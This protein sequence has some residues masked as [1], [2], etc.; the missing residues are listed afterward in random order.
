MARRRKK[1]KIIKKAVKIPTLFQCP[2]CGSNTLS[3]VFAKGESGRKAIVSCSR[4]GLY[5]EYGNVPSI[6]QAVDVYN[7]FIDLFEEG[8]V[9]VEFKEA[10]G[11]EELAEE[12]SEE[13]EGMEEAG[14]E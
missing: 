5:Y 14:E 11:L 10:A 2:N 6:Y 8:K 7:K 4:C 3:V 13:L 12:V 9:K 1:R